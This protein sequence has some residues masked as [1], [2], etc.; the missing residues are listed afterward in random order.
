[1]ILPELDEAWRAWAAVR[2]D[3]AGCVARWLA[4]VDA[5]PPEA[6]LAALVA[7]LARPDDAATRLDRAAVK[8]AQD[9]LRRLKFSND[10]LATAA[11][12]AGTG[13][14]CC[15]AAWTD[16]QVRRLLVDVTRPHAAAA[17]AVWRAEGARDLAD[18]AAAI[19]ERRD[20]LAAGEL[21]VTGKD[22]MAALEMSPGPAVGRLIAALLN[23]VLD[24]PALN[25][26]PR[27]LELA[28]QLELSIGREDPR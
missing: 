23:L 8:L 25:T 19:L 1:V 16:A 27:L 7:D 11:A 5:A 13:S 6:R 17:A 26:R 2:G 24:D 28:Q 18:R 9:V 22:L 21:A 3:R 4:R 12:V 10:E 20:P 15:V 14:A